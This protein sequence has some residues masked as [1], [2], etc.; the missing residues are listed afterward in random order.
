MAW[1]LVV[2]L[3]NPTNR[4][5]PP[6]LTPAHI[7]NRDLGYWNTSYQDLNFREHAPQFERPYKEIAAIAAR[8]GLQRIGID[9]EAHNVPVYPLLMLLSDH[10]VAYVRHTLMPHE[11]TQAFFPE[12]I[13]EIMPADRYRPSAESRSQP[14]VLYPPTRVTNLV[15]RMYRVR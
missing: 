2:M 4:L 7:G 10:R 13:V 3:F 5:L 15:I 9:S 8:E 12:A 1:A 14:D 6:A 11:I